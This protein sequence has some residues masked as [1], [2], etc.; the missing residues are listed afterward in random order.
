MIVLWLSFL[1]YLHEYVL[2]FFVRLHRQHRPSVTIV[3]NRGMNCV[4]STMSKHMVH[5]RNDHRLGVAQLFARY[6]TFHSKW[7]ILWQRISA[8][9][10]TLWLDPFDSVSR[11]IYSQCLFSVTHPTLF[12]LF[13]DRS[14]L[15][16]EDPKHRVATTIPCLFSPVQW[17]VVVVQLF[18]FVLHSLVVV[19]QRIEESALD[20]WC[21]LVEECAPALQRDGVQ[22]GLCCF[23]FY[24]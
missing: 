6:P 15:L 5:E 24:F 3:D 7:Y 19:T 2:S 1:N 14:I 9:D 16:V 13:L 8:R 18:E 11:S 20:S 4:R 23:C 22:K 12:W 10:C 21:E 17:F